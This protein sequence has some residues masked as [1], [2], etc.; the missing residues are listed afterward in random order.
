MEQY[1]LAVRACGLAVQSAPNDADLE[2]RLGQL[3]A[4][5][6]IQKGRYGEEGDFTKGVK[7]MDKQKELMQK[8]AFSKDAGYLEQQILKTKKEYE[9]NPQVA[10]KIN[11]Y[12]DALLKI[13]DEEHEN[14][15]I[16]LLEKAYQ[17]SGAYQFKMRVGDIKMRQMS[18]QFRELKQAGKPEE[19]KQAALEQL[20][21]EIQEYTER[22]QQYP[23]DLGMKYE[24][25]RRLFLA[26]KYDDAIGVLQQAQRD[27]RRFVVV[28]NYLGQA[29]MK[30]QWWQEAADTFDRVLQGDIPEE[31]AKDIRYNLGQC[32]E[33]MG[34]LKEA[35]EQ[36]STVAQT[37]FNF[38]DVRERLEAVRQKIKDSSS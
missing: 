31:R 35:Q 24:L 16:A 18:R 34:N 9:E 10:G 19:A 3:G 11:A 21:F 6:T 7:D 37:D 32:H 4:R 8:D 28:A 29:F 33:A 1:D 17:E 30:K 13:E 15:A 27:P 36:F 23:T 22:T 5:L 26:G 2:Q 14:Q 12:A 38:R 25:G 20:K